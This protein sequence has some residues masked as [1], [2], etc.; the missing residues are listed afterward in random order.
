MLL[1]KTHPGRTK[2]GKKALLKTIIG[3]SCRRH[4]FCCAKSFCCNKH[5]F[6]RVLRQTS[7]RCGKIFCRDKHKS[8]VMISILLSRQNTSFV[9]TKIILVVAPTNDTKPTL[10]SGKGKKRSLL[11]TYC[12][13]SERLRK[14]LPKTHR[15]RKWERKWLPPKLD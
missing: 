4:H 3:R 11:E 14:L 2:E 12:W 9:A 1:H 5:V 6:C 8:F 10:D 13:D 15:L 7:F